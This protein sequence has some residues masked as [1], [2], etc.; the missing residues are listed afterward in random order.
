MKNTENT[1][2]VET[3]VAPRKKKKLVVNWQVVSLAY[4]I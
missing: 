2:K 4:L 3:E 1:I